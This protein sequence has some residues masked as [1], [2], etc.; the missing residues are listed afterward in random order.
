MNT[1]MKIGFVGLALLLIYSSSIQAG[2]KNKKLIADALSAAPPTLKDKVTVVDWE[3]N[4]LKK[5][6]GSYTCF[7]T[8]PSL[9]GKAPMCM[10]GPWMKWADAWSNKKPL[11]IKNIGISYMLAGDGGA[12][13]IDPF[14][15]G[16]TKDNDWIKEGP[17][18][19]IIVPDP[20]LLDA[21]PTDPN[22]GGPYVMW[23]GTPY[24][25][26]MVPVGPRK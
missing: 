9:K 6:D 21:L 10:D 26:I 15:E 8:P 3:N 2:D 25:H 16:P 19:M 23:K 4:V 5:G 14:A 12:S 13:N 7:P 17:H 24:A 18:L 22:N 20:E 11:T 1:G